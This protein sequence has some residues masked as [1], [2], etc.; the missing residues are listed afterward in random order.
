MMDQE[1]LQ[2]RR[3]LFM[4]GGEDENEKIE[5][6][7]VELTGHKTRTD[8]K[9]RRASRKKET[10]SS[11]IVWNVGEWYKCSGMREMECDGNGAK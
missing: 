10:Q 2:A 6:K 7:V 4:P 8:K 5:G 1:L 9:E 11:W 3:R